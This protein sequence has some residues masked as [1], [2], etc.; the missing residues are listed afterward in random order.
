MAYRSYL[1]INATNMHVKPR[2]LL[3]I[4][5][6]ALNCL[7]GFK[8]GVGARNES[9]DEKP[10]IHALQRREK[11]VEFNASPYDFQIQ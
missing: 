4:P 6:L 3:S 5:R 1:S 2:D 11:F 10:G 9:R 7:T 8:V